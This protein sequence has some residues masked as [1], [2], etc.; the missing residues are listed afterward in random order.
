LEYAKVK[1]GMEE[2]TGAIQ[3]I[4]AIEKFLAQ[5]GHRGPSEVDV[6]RMRYSENLMFI[7]QALIGSSGNV[8]FDYYFD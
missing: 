4:S 5:Y 2:G 1:N 3:L 7:L 6:S 8:C